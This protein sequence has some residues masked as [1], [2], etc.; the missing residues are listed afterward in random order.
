MH[1][2]QSREYLDF[3]AERQASFLLETAIILGRQVHPLFTYRNAT[4][5]MAVDLSEAEALELAAMKMVK[6][7]RPDQRQHMLTD[8]GPEWLGAGAIWNGDGGLAAT[9]GEGIIVA[10]I[11]GGVNWDHASFADPGQDGHNHVNPL[12][13]QI[14]LCNLPQ[15]LCNNKLIGVYD[16]V[17]DDPQ[18]PDI[19]EEN[20]NGKDGDG[21]GS[22]TAATAVGN[23][24]NITVNGVPTTLSGVAPHAN[25]ITYRACW[26]G[27]PPD[28]DSGTCAGSAILEAIDQA[29]ADGVDV[30][31]YS[32]GGDPFDP[33]INGSVPRAFLNARN[34]GIFVA[35]AAGNEGPNP[36]TVGSPANAPWV[37]AVGNATH[38]RLLGTALNNLVGG[39]TLPPQGVSGASL[40]GG[41]GFHEIV[42]AKDFGFPLCGTGNSSSLSTCSV[43]PSSSNPWQGDTPFTGKI[44]V[45]D[46][47]EYGRIEKGRNLMQAGAEGYILANTDEWGEALVADNHCLPAIHVIESDGDSLR[48]WLDSGGGHQGAIGAFSLPRR[49]D[50]A[51]KIGISSSRGPIEAPVE[52]TLK[53]NLFGPGKD[54]LSAIET[55]DDFSAFS[56][57][58]MS[59]PHVAG[60]AALLKALHPQWSVA[61]ITSALET[62]STTAMARLH[63]GAPGTPHDYGAGRPQLE[64]AAHAGLFLDV[65]TQ[66]FT[67]ARPS[68]GGNPKNLNLAGLVD[69]NCVFTC[70]FTRSV[71]DQVGGA[72]WKATPVG[73]PP[74]VDVTVTPNDFTLAN[75]ASQALA[76]DID[77]LGSGLVNQWVYGTLDLT[78]AGLPDQR[79]TVALFSS[80]ESE[81]PEV[82]VIDDDPGVLGNPSDSN[83]GWQEF[84]LSGLPP[85]PDATFTSGGLVLPT[86]TIQTIVQDPTA[87]PGGSAQPQNEDPFDGGP[88]TFT[89]WENVP[90]GTL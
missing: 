35:A 17:V 39:D 88:G 85:L 74:G 4:N 76:I 42:H 52:D 77:L 61:Q 58:S 67:Q 82:W 60:S 27:I 89:V 5:G 7:L 53:P 40:N 71:T 86:V 21:H 69:A 90:A 1:A 84:Q 68:Q 31:N 55:Q 50:F 62:T 66:Q 49:D 87:D 57:T 12:G 18:T 13:N 65:T 81:L 2:P 78:S 70:S 37:M 83:G 43:N 47:G 59:S 63:D 14:G 8:A 11:D 22:H 29:I 3:L 6:S 26:V 28:L 54:I 34:A 36:A 32:L 72:D 41:S 75:G 33:W 73:F 51:D 30:I 10:S 24:I 9:E 46:R 56:G 45:C 23:R 20:S 64:Q 79:L 44:V 16:F 80:L 19:E 38:N 48:T 15:V 25:L